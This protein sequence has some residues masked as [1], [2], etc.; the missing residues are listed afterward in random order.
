MK[1]NF[2]LLSFV[3]ISTISFSQ[4]NFTY[5]VK[6]GA[7]YSGFRTDNGTNSDLFG[8]N[9]GGVAKIDLN[10]TF[11][12]QAELNLNSK[13][14]VY[15]FPLT[16]NNPEIRLTYLN[17]PVLLQTRITKKFCFEMGPEFGFL[18]NQKAKLNGDTFEIDDVPTFDMNL[19]VGLS[20]QFEKGVFIQGKYGYGLTE[21]FE[22]SDYKNS[23]ISLSLGYFFN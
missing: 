23:Y 16:S 8:I 5:G 1:T 6:A 21:L 18:V 20:Y 13:G 19:N 17:L 10:N 22:N 11:G 2:L 12:L 7:N 9:L 4:D 15:R 3:L 14:G